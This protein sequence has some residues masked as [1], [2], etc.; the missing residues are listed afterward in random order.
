MQN[1]PP[2]LR[3]WFSGVVLLLF[4]LSSFLTHKNF[5]SNTQKLIFHTKS[6]T[7][8]RS[9]PPTPIRIFEMKLSVV[10]GAGVPEFMLFMGRQKPRNPPLFT[11]M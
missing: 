11:F 5:T 3:L 4:T 7:L 6:F 1:L 10:Y 2:E 8:A 9:P